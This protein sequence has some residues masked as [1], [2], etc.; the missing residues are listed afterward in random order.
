MLLWIISTMRL[1]LGRCDW[2]TLIHFGQRTRYLVML[3]VQV[4]SSYFI[5][6][7]IHPIDW[8]SPIIILQIV[9]NTVI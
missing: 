8:S 7:L 9:S 6:D 1:S 5:F 3:T 2:A 4:L